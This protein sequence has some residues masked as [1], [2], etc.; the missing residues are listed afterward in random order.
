MHGDN[1]ELKIPGNYSK[2][3]GTHDSNKT[4]RH[5][6]THDRHTHALG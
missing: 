2:L 4:D 1:I 5:T 6:L 3:K